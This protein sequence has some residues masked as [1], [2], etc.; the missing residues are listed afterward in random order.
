MSECRQPKDCLQTFALS[1][2]VLPTCL[3]APLSSMT[4]TLRPAEGGTVELTS[5]T[6]KQCL[7]LQKCNDSIKIKLAEENGIVVGNFCPQGAI[8]KIQI[9]HNVT[10]T[11]SIV[12]LKPP[13]TPFKMSA[14][15]KKEIKGNKRLQSNKIN[16]CNKCMF[17]HDI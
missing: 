7:H 3:P 10:V 9:H 11:V 4:W 16:T 14:A 2:P 6:L 8:Q 1:V 12:G 17:L 13:T 5:P 15:F